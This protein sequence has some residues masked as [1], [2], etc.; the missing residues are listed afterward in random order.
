M[1]LKKTFLRFNYTLE[2]LFLEQFNPLLHHLP[3]TRNS[4]VFVSLIWCFVGLKA[5]FVCFLFVFKFAASTHKLMNFWIHFPSGKPHFLSSL[6][7]L[8]LPLAKHKLDKRSSVTWYAVYSSIPVM[9]SSNP[10]YWHLLCLAILSYIT[11]VILWYSEAIFP[12]SNVLGKLMTYN[13]MSFFF[14][15]FK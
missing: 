3:K 15:F 9:V 6:L 5:R 4:L 1:I 8:F 12:I 10:Y 14:F 13:K 2:V 11:S 7:T